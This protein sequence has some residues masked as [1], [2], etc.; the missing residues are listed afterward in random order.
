MYLFFRVLRDDLDCVYLVIKKEIGVRHT[1]KDTM[2]KLQK[3]PETEK[4]VIRRGPISKFVYIHH[5]Y[6]R[7]VWTHLSITELLENFREKLSAY[8]S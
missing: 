8:S 7:S 2:E 6:G 5:L 3:S 1:S 4:F